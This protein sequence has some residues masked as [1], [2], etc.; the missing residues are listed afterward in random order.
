MKEACKYLLEYLR[1][2]SANLKVEYF[3]SP[4]QFRNHKFT[5]AFKK[6]ILTLEYSFEIID[7]FDE[8]LSRET[9]DNYF[10]TLESKLKFDALIQLFEKSWLTNHSMTEEFLN[11]KRNWLSDYSSDVRF[12][13]RISKSI[14][15]GLV[16]LSGFL[17]SILNRTEFPIESIEN[18]LEICK[19]IIDYYDEKGNLNERRVEHD[20]PSFLKAGAIIEIINLEV[21]RNNEKIDRIKKEYDK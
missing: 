12:N 1:S 3:Y 5:I 6:E 14:Y 7:D 4:S 10:F 18:D 11:E 8:A 20:S 21:K 15:D 16:K 9:K 13:S 19:S 17:T 2:L